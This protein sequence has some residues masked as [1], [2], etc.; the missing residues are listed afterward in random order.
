MLILKFKNPVFGIIFIFIAL[1]TVFISCAR[2]KQQTTEPSGQKQ[3]GI[4]IPKE[5]PKILLIQYV[6]EI[7]GTWS[8][9][10]YWDTYD[11]G[12]YN[13]TYADTLK[14]Y[15]GIDLQIISPSELIKGMRTV[16][17]DDAEEM[18]GQWIKEAEA[19]YEVER[20]DIIQV[21]RMYLAVKE[22]LKKYSA[23]A[24]SLRSWRVIDS[25][26]CMPPL[27]EMQSYLDGNPTCCEGLVEP[28]VTQMMGTYISGRPGFIG[29]GLSYKMFELKTGF[30]HPEDVIILGHCYI[31]VNPHGNDRLPYVIRSHVYGNPN[32][33]VVQHEHPAS[34][35]V[36]NWGHWPVG[37]TV[38]LAKLNV[39]EKELAVFTGK[40]VD[41]DYY[42]QDFEETMCRDKLVVNVD[43]HENCFMFPIEKG[44]ESE[45]SPWRKFGKF[46]GHQVA[47]CGDYKD[48]MIELAGL[49][50]FDVTTTEGITE[51]PGRKL[52]TNT[53]IAMAIS[54]QIRP[55]TLHQD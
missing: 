9:G 51:N 54:E 24:W 48:E 32:A 26:L 7:N 27:A 50:G 5:P 46:G 14:K 18:A 6:D 16:A 40:I 30:K 17:E 10:N 53:N 1:N 8:F 3:E 35:F 33:T 42:Y 36:A 55:E 25:T 2:E 41:G 52:E 43:D 44:P 4:E 20:E 37:E 39:F 12:L 13:R 47:F 22:L 45:G 49:I 29:D 15:L 34:P 38:T 28:L 11:T 19:V 23:N 21:A 31:P